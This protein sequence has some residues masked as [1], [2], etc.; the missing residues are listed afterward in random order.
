[1]M[2]RVPGGDRDSNFA[3]R[4]ESPSGPHWTHGRRL[5][6]KQAMPAEDETSQAIELFLASD[7]LAQSEE[8]ACPYLPGRRARSA[9]F[10]VLGELDARIYRMLMDRGFRRS[11]EVIYRP[12]CA[13]CQACVPIRIPV[14]SF[15]PSRSQRRVWRRNADVRVETGDNRPT[16]EKYAL[17]ARYQ[18]EHHDGTMACSFEEFAHFGYA[19]TV[20]ALELCYYLGRRLVGVSLL[21]VVPDA[22]SSV[23]MFFDPA[24]AR[25]SLGT[26]SVLWEIAYCRDVG[27]AHYYLGYWVAGSRTMAYKANFGPAEFLNPAGQWQPLAASPP[28]SAAAFCPG[29]NSDTTRSPAD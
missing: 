25:R 14:A 12:M 26:F 3:E 7:G 4:M 17:F 16:D 8:H 15:A 28:P 6:W 13:S 2:V 5:R 29:S 1:M 22:L 11:G 10:S 18:R 9:G 21:D 20:P 27:R 24:E 19:G 23:Y